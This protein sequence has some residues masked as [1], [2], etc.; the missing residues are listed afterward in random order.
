LHHHF[1]TP[2]GACCPVRRVSAWFNNA[3]VGKT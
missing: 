1:L 3:T 2:D